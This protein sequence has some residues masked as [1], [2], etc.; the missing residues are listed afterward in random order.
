M[1]RSALSVKCACLADEGLRL[2]MRVMSVTGGCGALTEDCRRLLEVQPFTLLHTP[3]PVSVQDN[4][5]NTTD[6]DER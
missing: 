1:G 2:T 6:L 3:S 4:A 5:S